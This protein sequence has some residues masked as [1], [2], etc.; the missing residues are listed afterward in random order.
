MRASHHSH[1]GQFCKHATGSLEDVVKAAICDGFKI[2]GLT[3][4]VPRYRAQDLYPEEA[5]LTTHDLEQAFDSYVQEAH[6][7]KGVY[8]EQITLLVG[9]ESDYITANDLDQLD[10]LLTRYSGKI[11]YVVGSVHHCNGVPI[12][13]DKPTFERCVSSF[14]T[15]DAA[16]IDPHQPTDAQ[17]SYLEAYFD[18]QLELMQRVHPEVIGH[19]DLCRLYTPKLDLTGVWSRIERN[20]QYAIEYGAVFELNAAAF[21]KA[22]NSPYPGRDIVQLIQA[23]GGIFVLSDDS[24][25]PAAVGLNYTR[26]DEYIKE[27]K[28]HNIA[29]LQCLQHTNRAGRRTHPVVD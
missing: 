25:G 27:I 14:S 5:G 3:E 17:L 28:I 16:L 12:D 2:Y 6:R 22:W 15:A 11:E 9:L 18:A 29:H 26:L 21:R 10:A 20:V 13:F 23:M 8:A 24:H 19:F 1:S 7:L 4:H